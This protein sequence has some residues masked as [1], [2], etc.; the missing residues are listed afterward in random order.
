MM[1]VVCQKWQTILMLEN[2]I[3]CAIL[4]D[5]SCRQVSFFN[6]INFRYKIVEQEGE[7]I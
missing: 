5:I 7:H 1:K 6:N 2:E 4:R 3:Q